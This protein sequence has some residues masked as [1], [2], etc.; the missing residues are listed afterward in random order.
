MLKASA[1]LMLIFVSGCGTGLV[2]IRGCEGFKPIFISEHER[3][4][5]SAETL[6]EIDGHNTYWEQ[7][8]AG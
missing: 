4:T 1:V 6:N 2:G 3:L 7:N 5:M 8:C